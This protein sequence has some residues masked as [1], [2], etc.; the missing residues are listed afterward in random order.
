MRWHNCRNVHLTLIQGEPKKAT[1]TNFHSFQ[2]DEAFLMRF[3][4]VD[5]YLIKR[6]II[7]QY[8]KLTEQIPA[9]C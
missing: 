6:A 4:A 3:P 8:Y 2:M 1:G 5:R 7:C 9:S